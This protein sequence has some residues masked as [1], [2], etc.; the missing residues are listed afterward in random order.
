MD[1]YAKRILKAIGKDGEMSL[2]AAIKLASQHHLSH[3]DQYPLA[4]LIEGGYV[5]MTINHTPPDGAEDM[6]EFSL[7][8]TLHMF[9][10]P[11][12]DDGEVHYMD[13]ISR[14]SIA[15]KN[16]RV[17]LKAKGALY[18]DTEREKRLDRLYAL[19]VG[20]SAGF[21]SAFMSSW[22]YDQIK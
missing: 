1:G 9:G 10:M 15:P 16:E 12:N 22:L 21:L 11:R 14:G 7:A 8:T 2:D 6:R 5:G 19:L 13:M 20:F 4:L 3:A 17:F 18:L